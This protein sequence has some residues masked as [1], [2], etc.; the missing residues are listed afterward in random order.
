MFQ[1]INTYSKNIFF[2]ANQNSI[3]M[4]LTKINFLKEKLK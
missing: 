1:Y 4:D 2:S 3:D